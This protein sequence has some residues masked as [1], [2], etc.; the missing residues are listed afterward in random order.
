[1]G[2][3]EMDKLTDEKIAKGGVLVKFYFDMQHKEKEK[4]QPL[5]ADLINERLMKEK[6]VVYC[7]GSIE[8]PIEKDGIYTTSAMI[9]VLFES[10]FPLVGIAFN[11]APAGLEILRP[12]KEL[13]FT[14]AEMQSLLLELSQISVTYSKYILEHVM[15]PEEIESLSKTMDA[16]S[17]V[18]KKFIGTNDDEQHAA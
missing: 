18:G 6:G 10:F 8:E 12:E 2:K 9:T 7:Y 3:S 16:R 17:E 4:L 15:K 11:Y 13:K 1:M 14:T 5:M